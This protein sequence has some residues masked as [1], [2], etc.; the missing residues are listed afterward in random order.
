MGN[1]MTDHYADQDHEAYL[2]EVKIREEVIAKIC[3]QIKKIDV[4][5]HRNPVYDDLIFIYRNKEKILRN[6]KL[7]EILG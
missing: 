4:K 6:R 7:I 5:D 2:E 1:S 3:E